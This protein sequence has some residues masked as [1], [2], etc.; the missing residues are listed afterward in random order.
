MSDVRPIPAPGDPSSTRPDRV[1]QAVERIA[2]LA[3]RPPAEHVLP[4]EEAHRLLQDA[5]ASLDGT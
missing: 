1:D 5:L 3:G 2:G 4:L